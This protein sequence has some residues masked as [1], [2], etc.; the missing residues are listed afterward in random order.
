MHC[1]LNLI[2][3]SRSKHSLSKNFRTSND[4]DCALNLHTVKCALNKLIN[5]QILTIC[6]ELWSITLYGWSFICL[7]YCFQWPDCNSSH[8]F[9]LNFIL[10][11]KCTILSIRYNWT[12][13]LLT[14]VQIQRSRLSP[15]SIWN[16]YS[17]RF[18]HTL[19]QFWSNRQSSLVFTPT[20]N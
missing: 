11:N 2:W 5:M 17:I 19:C 15:N 14:R 9:F 18:K 16:G 1:W 10:Y 7:S 20:Y 12:S 13:K 6:L 8:I 4:F 3:E